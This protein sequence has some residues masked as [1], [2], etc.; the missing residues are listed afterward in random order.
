MSALFNSRFH[1]CIL[2]ILRILYLK[3]F[4][5]NKGFTENLRHFEVFPSWEGIC[6]LF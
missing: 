1:H 3:V 4:C 5:C 2:G 6:Y